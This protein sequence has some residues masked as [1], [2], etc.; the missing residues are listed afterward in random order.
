MNL[1]LGLFGLLGYLTYEGGFVL[2]N[3][4]LQTKAGRILI[5]DYRYYVIISLFGLLSF[6]VSSLFSVPDLNDTAF[7][8]VWSNPKVFDAIR[9]FAI[10]IATVHLYKTS[11]K[12]LIKGVKTETTSAAKGDAS[13]R[14]L[15]EMWRRG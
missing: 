12:S 6:I 7:P 5:F 8:P 2:R 14:A 4:R 15:Y 11:G 10:G 9:A 1:T 13:F 3:F